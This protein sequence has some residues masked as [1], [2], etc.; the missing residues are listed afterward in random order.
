M[1]YSTG[2]TTE[3]LTL[4]NFSKM[5]ADC[6][7]RVDSKDTRIIFHY[8]DIKQDK[9]ITR[10]EFTFHLSLTEYDLDH[11]VDVM[12][13]RLMLVT[14]GASQIKHNRLLRDIFRMIN[15]EQTSILSLVDVMA[16]CARFNIFVTEE[17]ARALKALMDT[18]G[19]DKV[20]EKDFLVFM[21]SS[22]SS[23]HR[24]AQRVKDAVTLLRRWLLRGNN[25]LSDKKRSS[26][27]SAFQSNEV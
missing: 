14:K 21:K 27:C 22:V 15:I 18:D 3:V 12:K 6:G 16:L 26:R 25:G 9:S 23:I 8:F 7:L 20:G 19:D 11:V 17:E 5:L 2:G 1:Q 13:E 4:S 24:S 10:V